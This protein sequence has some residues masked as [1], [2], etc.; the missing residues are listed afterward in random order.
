MNYYT[1]KF[2]REKK[3]CPKAWLIK[4]VTGIP[5]R[6]ELICV[7]PAAEQAAERDREFLRQQDYGMMP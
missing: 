1:A 5:G 4:P 6:V 7:D 3:A 2:E